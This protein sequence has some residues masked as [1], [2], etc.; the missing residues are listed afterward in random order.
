M[1]W[2]KIRVTRTRIWVIGVIFR[3]FLVKGIRVI[4]A[5]VNWVQMTEKW[6]EVLPRE[7]GV[8]SS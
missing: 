6:G 7:I 2:H 5:Q 1:E 3:D 8:S 4:R